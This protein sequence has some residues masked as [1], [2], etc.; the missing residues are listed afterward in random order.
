MINTIIYACK[1]W[2]KLCYNDNSKSIRSNLIT[3]EYKSGYHRGLHKSAEK[4][5]YI[6]AVFWLG[7]GWVDMDYELAKRICKKF[8]LDIKLKKRKMDWIKK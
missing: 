5:K 4:A 7:M 3:S 8:N 1:Q 2:D 6:T